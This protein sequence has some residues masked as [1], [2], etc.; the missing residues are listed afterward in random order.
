M[1][2]IFETNIKILKNYMKKYVKR[3]SMSSYTDR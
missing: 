1:Y 2:R 3:M